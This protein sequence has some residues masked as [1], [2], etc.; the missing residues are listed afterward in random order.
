MALLTPSEP[1]EQAAA[2]ARGGEV[3]IVASRWLGGAWTQDRLRERLGIGAAI[4]RATAGRRGGRAGGVHWSPS[5]PGTG[6]QAGGDPLGGRAGRHRPPAA[7]H[8]NPYL[9]S[10][11]WD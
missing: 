4:R 10:R 9:K 11:S 2:A 8:Q 1:T 5:A 7:R 3:E 6:Q